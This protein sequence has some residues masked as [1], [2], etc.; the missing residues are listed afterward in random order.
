MS[1]TIYKEDK[2][3]TAVT[4]LK[5]APDPPPAAL[6]SLFRDNYDCIY[7]AA[8]RVTGSASDAEDVLQTV[9]LRLARRDENALTLAPSPSAYLHRAAVNASLDLLRSRRR[10]LTEVALEETTT[11]AARSGPNPETQQVD[12]ELNQLIRAAVARLGGRAAE[13]FSLRYL[14][15]YDNREIAEI[16]GTSRVVVAVT[17]HRS[18]SRLR[19]EIR[20]Y[21]EGHNEKH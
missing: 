2:V 7:R 12:R 8:Y 10:G 14:E 6:E 21:L 11:P 4:H 1:R 19:Q 13:I 3:P 18:R 17:L 5:R 9:F 15:G 20:Q 16:V